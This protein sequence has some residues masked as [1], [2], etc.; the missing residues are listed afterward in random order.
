MEE[1]N[2]E[3]SLEQAIDRYHQAA[4]EGDVNAQHQLAKSYYQ[5]G[6]YSKSLYWWEKTAE[7]GFNA[8]YVR[9]AIQ[10]AYGLG[11]EKDEKKALDYIWAAVKND[12]ADADALCHLGMFY[13]G[14][15]GLE[16]SMEQALTCYRQAAELG[17]A[18][19]HFTL[20]MCYFSGHG[21]EENLETALE[22]VDKSAEMNCPEGQYFMGLQYYLGDC[23]ARDLHRAVKYLKAGAENGSV[24]AQQLLPV[25][26]KN[27][28][29]E[30]QMSNIN[31]FS[32]ML[33]E[34]EVYL[35]NAAEKMGCDGEE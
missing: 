27:I 5:H 17:S 1:K 18:I 16:T 19:A 10:Y 9:L 12:P 25:V 30:R 2:W 15:I 35:K 26:E 4:Q 11:T 13:E 8:A 6:E 7:A 22:W 24:D 20:G 33:D 31:G 3:L 23:V 32:Q 14:G 34:Y 29:I 28:D 21:V